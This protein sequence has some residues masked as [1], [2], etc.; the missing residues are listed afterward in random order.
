[1]YLYSTVLNI[2]ADV[3]PYDVSNESEML[4]FKPKLPVAQDIS[5]PIFWVRKDAGKWKVINIDD[6]TIVKQVLASIQLNK[7]DE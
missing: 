3:I 1:M 2:A 5:A 7:V 6:E 4:L